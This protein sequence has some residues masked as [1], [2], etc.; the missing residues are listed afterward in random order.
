M[1]FRSQ[2]AEAYQEN[3][4]IGAGRQPTASKMFVIIHPDNKMSNVSLNNLYQTIEEESSD[5][6]LHTFNEK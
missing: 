2:L 3:E 6:Y 1:L 4:G 5:F